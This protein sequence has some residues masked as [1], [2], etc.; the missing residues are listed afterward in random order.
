MT[1]TTPTTTSVERLTM[2]IRAEVAQALADDAQIWA[3]QVAQALGPE[4][5]QDQVTEAR[6]AELAAEETDRVAALAMA[7][8][9]RFGRPSRLTT[10]QEWLG[11]SAE[12]FDEVFLAALRQE[13]HLEALRKMG[14]SA[15]KA[16]DD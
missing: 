15:E 4:S 14:D 7:E 5:P 6:L 3:R 8:L 10:L 13:C 2:A 11:I 1:D 12:E 9:G 16:S